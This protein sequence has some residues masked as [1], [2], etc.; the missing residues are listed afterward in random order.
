MPTPFQV[1]VIQ[2]FVMMKSAF[3]VLT[4]MLYQQCYWFSCHGM[5]L[6]DSVMSVKCIVA[7]RAISVFRK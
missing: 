5:R 3:P 6:Y 4:G 2:C 1:V 7:I